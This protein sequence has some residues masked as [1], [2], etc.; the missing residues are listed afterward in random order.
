M[1]PSIS[2]LF[3]YENLKEFLYASVYII[4]SSANNVVELYLP[5]GS[6]RSKYRLIP[7]LVLLIDLIYASC[8]LDARGLIL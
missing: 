8:V 3:W 2:V 1:I 4:P 5:V 7:E 6:D